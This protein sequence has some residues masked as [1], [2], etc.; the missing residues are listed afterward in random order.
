MIMNKRSLL[1]PLLALLLVPAPSRAQ[2]VRASRPPLSVNVWAGVRAPFTTGQLL[3]W[4]DAG[5]PVFWGREQHGGSPALGAQLAVPLVGPLNLMVEGIYSDAGRSEFFYPDTA[6]SGAPDL[7]VNIS[8][9]MLM[10]RAGLGLHFERAAGINSVR[11]GASTDLVVGVG[12]V[13]YFDGNHPALNFGFDGSLPITPV[14][15]FRVG[16][17]DFLVFWD[18]STLQ[19]G[20]SQ[21]FY[22][23]LGNSAGDA[24]IADVRYDTSNLFV[25]R[26]G[27]GLH[28]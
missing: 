2:E 21:R 16:I 5:A 3:V 11:P 19:A 8:G 13:R 15:D 27:F 25:L 20:L 1:V 23:I 24:Y 14:L 4:N 12:G 18:R 9:T 6:W 10:A 7:T 17:E 28:L 22:D 26:A